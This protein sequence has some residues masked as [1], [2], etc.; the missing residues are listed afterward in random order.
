MKRLT[1]REVEISLECLPETTAIEGNV[2]ASGDDALDHA[3]ERDVRERLMDG[4]DWAWCA[5]RITAAWKQFTGKAYLC[6]CSYESEEDFK[7]QSGYYLDMVQEALDELNRSIEETAS[8]LDALQEE[9][10]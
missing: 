5:V 4:N 9:R 3:A 6:C 2:L 8:A 10:P 1:E 7:A